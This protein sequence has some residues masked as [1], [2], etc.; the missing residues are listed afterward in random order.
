M[1][2]ITPT[3]IT[4]QLIKT[5]YLRPRALY[6]LLPLTSHV[7]VPDLRNSE[8]IVDIFVGTWPTT[9]ITMTAN[10]SC[11]LSV[12]RLQVNTSLNVQSKF[13]YT[14]DILLSLFL[15]QY[16]LSPCSLLNACAFTL[17]SRLQCKIKPLK[18]N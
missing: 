1:K 5:L 7:I 2:S 4:P 10:R 16:V 3:K 18:F 8:E 13:L 11:K 9:L 14:H 6:C 15:L 17:H 12:S